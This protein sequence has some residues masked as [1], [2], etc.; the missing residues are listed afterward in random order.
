MK[1]TQTGIAKLA[2]AAGAT[3]KIFFDDDLPGFGVRVRAGGSRSTRWDYRDG[4]SQRRHTIGA[5]AVVTLEEARKK[6]RKVLVA[7]DDGRDPATDKATNRAAA[8]LKFKAVSL[9]YL[10]SC[11]GRLKAG[12]LEQCRRYLDAYWTPLHGVAVSTVTRAMVAAQL[13]TITTDHGP[14][15]ADRCR[16]TLSAFYVWAIGEGLCETNPVTG[17]NKSGHDSERERV[18]TDAELATVWSA[19]ADNDFGRIVRLLMLTAQRRDEIGSLRWSE[20]HAANDSAKALVALPGER[21]K[22]HRPHDVPLSTAALESV[23]DQPRIAGRD[24]VFGAGE[25]GFSGWSKAKAALDEACGVTDWTLHDLRRTAATRMADLGVQP[26]V[27]EAILNHV[28]GHKAGVAGIYNRSL[29]PLRSGPRWTCGPITCAS[30]SHKRQVLMSPDCG[31]QKQAA[32]SPEC[33]KR[34]TRYA[35]N[36]SCPLVMGRLARCRTAAQRA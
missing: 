8:G 30:S 25:G 13:R 34:S 31:A 28:S 12:Y 20:I 4:G 26:H 33:C 5:V 21:T 11:E 6:A 24:L 29:M 27:I 23:T 17:T 9:Q 7:V 2:L 32:C 3:D 35:R 36:G 1:L 10:A 14:I 22:N 19:T 15:S 18:L 16:A